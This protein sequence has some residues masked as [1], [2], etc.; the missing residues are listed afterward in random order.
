MSKYVVDDVQSPPAPNSDDIVLCPTTTVVG[1]DSA[2]I[3]V[4][5]DDTSTH[6]RDDRIDGDQDDDDDDNDGAHRA[7]HRCCCCRR[8]HYWVS[9]KHKL[10]ADPRGL[11]G[12]VA[13]ITTTATT[14]TATTI[15]DPYPRG[16]P[17]CVW[18]EPWQNVVSAF[19][20]AF[21]SIALFIWWSASTSLDENGPLLGS[22][23]ASAVLFYGASLSRWLARGLVGSASPLHPCLT[24]SS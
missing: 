2:A 8:R 4:I 18:P 15:G 10:L 6:H 17:R 9:V 22:I 5:S 14:A 20:G 16:G 3:V 1:A 12:G 13:T 21:V 23:G 19:L 11:P 7:Y 24:P